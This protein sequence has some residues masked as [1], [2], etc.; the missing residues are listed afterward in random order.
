M[1]IDNAHSLK[2]IP[3]HAL[4]NQLRSCYTGEF[5]QEEAQA[6]LDRKYG[7][8][9]YRVLELCPANCFAKDSDHLV[10]A[11]EVIFARALP[12]QLRV[13]YAGVLSQE[14]V[15]ACLGSEYR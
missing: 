7:N 14:E 2:I 10:D 1:S 3:P 11:T 6:L 13:C 4:T 12:N 8:N 5:S 15:Q 9:E